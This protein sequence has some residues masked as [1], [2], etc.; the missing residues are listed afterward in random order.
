MVGVSVSV[1]RGHFKLTP[2]H[3]LFFKEGSLKF[4]TKVFFTAPLENANK[5]ISAITYRPTQG[6]YG[7]TFLQIELD[8]QGYSGSNG[9]LSTK[10]TVPI[11]YDK[12]PVIPP[13]V[14][15]TLTLPPAVLQIS[16]ATFDI[17]GR[18]SAVPSF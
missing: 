5:A 15:P 17:T 14:G 11:V 13:N 10:A 18:V 6:W 7:T 16:S 8:D 3:G 12:K 4:S 2:I 9:Q 1:S